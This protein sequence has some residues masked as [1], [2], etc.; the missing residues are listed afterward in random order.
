MT[1]TMNDQAMDIAWTYE[2]K[3]DILVLSRENPLKTMSVVNTFKKRQKVWKVF[4]H[5][6]INKDKQEDETENRE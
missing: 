5:E 2:I 1:I 4:F 6:R 3:G